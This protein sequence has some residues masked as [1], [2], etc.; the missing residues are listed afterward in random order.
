MTTSQNITQLIKQANEYAD[1]AGETAL[2][3]R[4]DENHYKW[5]MGIANIITQLVIELEKATEDKNFSVKP[6]KNVNKAWEKSSQAQHQRTF[7]NWMRFI[8]QAIPEKT[9]PG[10]MSPMYS[11]PDDIESQNIEGYIIEWVIGL[12]H[13]LNIEA[14]NDDTIVI[15]SRD[16]T[17]GIDRFYEISY[18]GSKPVDEEKEK[19]AISFC[20]N[21]LQTHASK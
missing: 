14:E 13:I 10:F 21:W 15:Y 17:N 1:G 5:H 3:A 6:K 7:R 8:Q 18:V 12:D 2:K 11:D 19:E 20:R 9:K 4:G 16:F